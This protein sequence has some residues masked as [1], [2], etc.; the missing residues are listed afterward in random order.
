VTDLYFNARA[1]NSLNEEKRHQQLT[2]AE[3]EP[4]HLCET[5][6]R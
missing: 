4:F 6:Q 1:F 2:V 5:R 3:I